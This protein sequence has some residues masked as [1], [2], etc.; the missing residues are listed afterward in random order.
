MK[1]I[2]VYGSGCR[3]C[4]ITAERVEQVAQQLNQAIRLTK[5]SDLEAIMKAGVVSTPAVAIDGQLVHTGSVPTLE[6]L[7]ELLGG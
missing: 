6:K 7:E 3:N 5:V 2:N 4:V 1:E